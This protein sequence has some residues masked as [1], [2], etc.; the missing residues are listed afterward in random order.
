LIVTDASAILEVLLHTPVG[1]EIAPH[2]FA[3]EETIHAPYLVDIEILHAVRRL[4]RSGEVSVAR[5][6]ELLEDYSD[7]SL[8]RYPHVLFLARI[9]EL[10]HNWTAYEAAY[11]AL[12]EEL[13]APLFT[14]DRAL[15]TAGHRA[16]V[17][18][19]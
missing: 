8:Q 2:I 3:P 11:I 17:L 6:R 10:R 14:C 7:L 19:M 4:N 16:K 1:L 12:A 15:A 18:V 5:A 13:D 9:W